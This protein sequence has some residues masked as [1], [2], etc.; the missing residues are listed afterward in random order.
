MIAILLCAISLGLQCYTYCYLYRDI[1]Y[2]YH[3]CYDM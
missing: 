3:W 1:C 2:A